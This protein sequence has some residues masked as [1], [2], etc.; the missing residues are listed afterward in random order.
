MTITEYKIALQNIHLYAYHGVMQQ[1]QQIGA[2]FTIDTELTIKEHH[3]T[4]TDDINGTVSYADVYDIIVREMSQPSKLLEN[5][6]HRI[7]K[8]IFE[9]FS[10]VTDINITVTKETPPMGGD[11]LSAAVTLSATR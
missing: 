5:V 10:I 7:I 8:S 1:E 3:C 2:W 6:A 11:R 9:K 4:A